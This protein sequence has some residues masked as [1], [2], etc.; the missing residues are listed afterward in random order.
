[1]NW[2]VIG[3]YLAAGCTAAGCT[4]LWMAAAFLVAFPHEATGLAYIELASRFM[5]PEHVMERLFVPLLVATDIVIDWGLKHLRLRGSF[6]VVAVI[7]T[8]AY[9]VLTIIVPYYQPMLG[10]AVHRTLFG[11]AVALVAVPRFGSYFQQPEM[12]AIGAPIP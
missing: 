7:A 9:V 2:R 12:H 11:A 5:S 1:M 10:D 8:I 6:A 3:G 4:L